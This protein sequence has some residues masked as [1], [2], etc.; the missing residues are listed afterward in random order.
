VSYLVQGVRLAVVVPLA[1]LAQHFGDIVHVDVCDRPLLVLDRRG[2][3]PVLVVRLDAVL[4]L[5]RRRDHHRLPL[6]D[7][8]E[9]NHLSARSFARV[10]GLV[11]HRID[12]N[13]V[14]LA[15]RQKKQ[16]S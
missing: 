16:R 9:S 1:A 11:L 15:T 4:P 10:C 14:V 12:K 7:G 5:F 8:P 6:V 2:D 13:I 3:G